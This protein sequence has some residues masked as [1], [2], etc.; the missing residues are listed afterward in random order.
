MFLQCL[1]EHI[2]LLCAILTIYQSE[3]HTTFI[4]LIFSY[5]KG[6][7]LHHLTTQLI[8]SSRAQVKHVF[9]MIVLE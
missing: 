1:E 4:R 2:F 6:S 3:I 7:V 8:E 9:N 5:N